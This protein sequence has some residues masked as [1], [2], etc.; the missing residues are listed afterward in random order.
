MRNPNDLLMPIILLN[1]FFL[2][3]YQLPNSLSQDIQCL[4]VGLGES[5]VLGFSL[6]DLVWGV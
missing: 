5:I 6:V 1:F 3:C 4:G 2:C